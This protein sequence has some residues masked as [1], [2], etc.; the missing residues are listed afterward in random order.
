MRLIVGSVGWDHPGWSEQFYPDDLP[1]EWRLSYYANEFQM[2]LLPLDCWLTGNQEQ[3][4][5]WREDVSDRFDF[6]LDITGMA[7]GDVNAMAQLDRCQAALGD[8]LAGVASWVSLAEPVRGRV[9]SLLGAEARFLAAATDPLEQES[10]V[11]VASNAAIGCALIPGDAGRDL[12]WLRLVMESLAARFSGAS[13]LRL[14]FAGVPPQVQV[15]RE[16]VILWQ[17]LYGSGR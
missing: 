7:T 13:A 11:Q 9:Q 12:K 17:L 14:F 4:C 6:I 5:A 10:T 8:R 3:L 15:M 1:P 2:V 16:A